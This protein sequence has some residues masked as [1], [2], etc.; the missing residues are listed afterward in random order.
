MCVTNEENWDVIKR[1]NIWGVPDRDKQRVQAVKAGDILVIYVMP[2]KI[3]G[4]FEA[5]SQSFESQDKL[6]SWGD[7]GR[8]EL[9][10]YR[11]KMRPL[12]LPKELLSFD[13]L[14]PKLRFITNKKTWSGHLRRA[15][16]IIPKEDYEKIKT[17]FKTYK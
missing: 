14:I 4:I 11:V 12:V 7:F 2:K 17:F 5:T 1:Q 16:R 3:G 8:E 10:P 6:F 9:F 13:K 15:M